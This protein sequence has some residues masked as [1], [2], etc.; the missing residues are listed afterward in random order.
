MNGGEDDFIVVGV[1]DKCPRMT[2]NIIGIYSFDGSICVDGEEVAVG[3]NFTTGD[4]VSCLISRDKN[5]EFQK[6][7]YQFFKNGAKI[8]PPRY[9]VGKKLYPLVGLHSTGAVINFNLGRKPFHYQIGKAILRSVCLNKYYISIYTN[10]MLHFCFTCLIFCIY[11]Y[12]LGDLKMWVYID[13][14]SGGRCVQLV[15][16]PKM[17]AMEMV[18]IV[19]KEI[20]NPLEME[21]HVLHEVVLQGHLERPIHY[22]EVVFE[23]TLKWG[24][25]PE[26]DRRDNYLLLK[27]INPFYEEALPHAVPPV[28]V[29]G[30]ALEGFEKHHLSI[31]YVGF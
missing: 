2:S 21:N 26:E 20:G 14:K 17:T 8:G 12:F 22:K 23:T 5:G 28:S 19:L 16:Y 27:K 18:G 4:T 3:E 31:R 25:W 9:L 29:F 11:I 24:T 13:S 7:F 10:N 30:E 15:V 6:T 1:S